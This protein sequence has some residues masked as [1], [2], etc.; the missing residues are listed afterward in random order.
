MS[1]AVVLDKPAGLY[2]P[3]VP[4]LGTDPDIKHCIQCG[5]CSGV[6]PWGYVMEYP[7]SRMISALRAGIF[8]QVT[9]TDSVWMCIACSACTTACP[10]LIPITEHLMTRIKEELILA[11]RV[12]TELQSALEASHRYGNPLGESPRR[13]ADWTKEA[14][15]PVPILG[16][17]KHHTD[18]LWF[19]GDYPAY[20]PNVKPTSFAL[21]AIFNALGVDFGIL[22]NDEHSDGDSQRLAGEQGLFE[23]LAEKNARALN[24]Y[25]FYEIVTTDPHAYNAFRNSYPEL[26]IIHPVRHY[27]QYLAEKI[28]QLKPLLTKEVKATVTYHD[29]CYLGRVNGIYDEPRQLLEAIPGIELVEMPHHRETSLCCGGG[30]GGMWLDGYQWEKSHARTSEWRVKEAKRT[31]AQ[32]LVVACPYEKPRFQDAIKTVRID[33]LEVMDLTE[34]LV[35]AMM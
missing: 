31:G 30:G 22:G 8:D 11:G 32:I 20:H 2:D 1:Q 34:L 33:D 5:N 18:I 28:E 26:G 10:S 3:D 14:G 35:K 23:T 15:V 6:C 27:T 21:A 25:S 24:K 19:V 7:P 13:R 4:G 16:K 12:P 29:P 9:S 17:N